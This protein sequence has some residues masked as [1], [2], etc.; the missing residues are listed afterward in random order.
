MRGS[1]LFRKQGVYRFSSQNHY[2]I[3]LP[4]HTLE[5]EH[6]GP[7]GVLGRAVALGLSRGCG[8]TLGAA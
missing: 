2:L 8:G 6:L 3:I 7:G 1:V 5:T 4:Q